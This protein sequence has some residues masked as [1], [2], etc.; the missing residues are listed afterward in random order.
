M[1]NG[2]GRSASE[3]CRGV[4]RPHV[5]VRLQTESHCNGKPEHDGGRV[6]GW[7][8]RGVLANGLESVAGWLRKERVS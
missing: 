5:G 6:D 8:I 2:Q 1:R 3:P 4:V 7:S